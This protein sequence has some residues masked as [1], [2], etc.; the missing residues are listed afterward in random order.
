MKKYVCHIYYY[1][2]HFSETLLILQ[3]NYYN[4]YYFIFHS[5]YT[6]ILIIRKKEK[7][8]IELFS[9]KIYEYKVNAFLLAFPNRYISK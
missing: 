8:Y 9:K 1:I 4:N 7:I 5:N 3:P 2:N 6:I